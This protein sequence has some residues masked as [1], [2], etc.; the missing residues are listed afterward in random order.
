MFRLINDNNK[1]EFAE[2]AHRNYYVYRHP[3]YFLMF[4][5]GHDYNCRSDGYNYANMDHDCEPTR[6]H[7]V[8]AVDAVHMSAVHAHI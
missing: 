7:A 2:K 5:G 8:H 3:N 4:G 1:I 6:V